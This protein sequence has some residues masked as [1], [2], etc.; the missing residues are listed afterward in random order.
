MTEV[1]IF[2]DEGSLPRYRGDNLTTI[3]DRVG[4]IH[5][6]EDAVQAAARFKSQR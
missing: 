3:D 2:K 5:H 4:F 6:L 1:H